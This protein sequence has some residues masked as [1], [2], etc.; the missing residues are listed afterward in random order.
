MGEGFQRETDPE[1]GLEAD[2]LEVEVGALV[3]LVGTGFVLFVAFLEGAG[4]PDQGADLLT[5]SAGLL[6][7]GALAGLWFDGKGFLLEDAGVLPEGGSF[8]LPAIGGPLFEGAASGGFLLEGAD[9]L[10]GTDFL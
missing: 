6:V 8:R 5:G 1:A 10:L 9:A 7:R 3:L 2:G 4:V